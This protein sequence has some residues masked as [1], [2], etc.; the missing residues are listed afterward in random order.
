[1]GYSWSDRKGAEGIQLITDSAGNHLTPLYDVTNRNNPEKINFLIAQNFLGNE[2]D[3]NLRGLEDLAGLVTTA[4]LIDMLDF[5]RKDFNKV[6]SL[7]SKKSLIVE[8]KW[9]LVK[10]GDVADIQ[11]GGTPSSEIAEYWDGDI[12]WAT[13]V[14]TKNKY[15]TNT[16]RKITETGLKNSSAK[17]LPINTVIFSSRATIGDVTIAKVETATN[18]GYKNFICNEK[19]EHEYLY[20]ILKYYA[21]EIASLAAGM[22]FKEISKTVISNFKIPLPPKDIQQQI[23]A[24][25]EE[26]DKNK[27]HLLTEG[28]SMKDFENVIKETKREILKKY[29]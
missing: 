7:T 17:L 22:T 25:I 1:M 24:E 11:S 14:D 23:V 20:Y 15:L 4:R 12:C 19:I 10:L 3:L 9:D 8:T 2:L 27:S 28:M 18:Q 6:I 26:L 5:S 16:Q 13:L 29:L 21:N